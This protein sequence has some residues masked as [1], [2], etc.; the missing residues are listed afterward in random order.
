M[1]LEQYMSHM[2]KNVSVRLE[3]AT[4]LLVVVVLLLLA[5]VIYYRRLH[6]GIKRGLPPFLPTHPY[7]FNLSR[8]HFISEGV[9]WSLKGVH[10]W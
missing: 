7:L 10:S 2:E 5:Y 9:V 3:I 4:T 6:R 8:I 1:Q